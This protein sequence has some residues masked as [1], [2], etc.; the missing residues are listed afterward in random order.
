[1]L[2]TSGNEDKLKSLLKW[3]QFEVIPF[4]FENVADKP[5]GLKSHEV[6]RQVIEKETGLKFK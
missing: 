2:I 4:L 3:F 1:M 6:D 5:S